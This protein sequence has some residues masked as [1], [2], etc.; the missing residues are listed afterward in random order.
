M[1]STSYVKKESLLSFVINSV[2]SLVFLYLVFYPVESLPVWGVDGLLLDSLIQGFVIGLMASL[3][4]TVITSKRVAGGKLN[5]LKMRDNWLSRHFILAG[6]LFALL[7]ALLSLAINFGGFLWLDINSVSFY[8]ALVFK[9]LFGGVLGA[10]VTYQ[11]LSILK[12]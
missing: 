4:P 2:L 8:S 3:V 9:V 10:L 1:E 7:S 5:R 11:S 6:L 12:G